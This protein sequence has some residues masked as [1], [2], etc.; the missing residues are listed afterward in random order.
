MVLTTFLR[1]P[2]A[3]RYQMKS[4]FGMPRNVPQTVEQCDLRVGYLRSA[5][6]EGCQ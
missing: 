5:P 6:T 1:S 3:T 2:E 4:F